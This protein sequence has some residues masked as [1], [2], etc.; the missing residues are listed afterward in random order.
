[1]RIAHALHWQVA[2]LREMGVTSDEGAEADAEKEVTRCGLSR[3]VAFLMLLQVVQ[4][5]WVEPHGD[6]RQELVF[7]GSRTMQQ[8]RITRALD[9]ALLTD[10]EFKRGPK[11]WAKLEDPIAV[12]SDDDVMEFL[13]MD[14]EDEDDEEDDDGSSDDD[15]AVH[16]VAAGKR[17]R[18]ASKPHVHGAH[19]N[20]AHASAAAS[21]PAPKKPQASAPVATASGR[22]LRSRA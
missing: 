4:K 6:R 1:M 17:G 14:E 19:C 22:S 16:A 10:A 13:E 21:K 12:L 7:I 5:Y 11:A 8:Q 20:H 3:D 15:E 9:A 2:A 18:G